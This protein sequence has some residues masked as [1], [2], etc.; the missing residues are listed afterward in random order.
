MSNEPSDNQRPDNVS[1]DAIEHPWVLSA[2]VFCPECSYSLQ[3]I[4]SDRCP[5]C[6]YEL[7]QLKSLESSIPW[8]RRKEI[9][10]WRAY[11]AT[12]WMV[13]FRNR[14]FCNEIAKPVSYR[15]SQ[16]YRWTTVVPAAIPFVCLFQILIWNNLYGAA[17]SDE[18]RTL[19]FPLAFLGLIVP[20]LVA[21]AATGWPSY[22][23]H[24]K[25]LPVAVQNRAIALSYYTS[26]PLVFIA[27]PVLFAGLA[28]DRPPT[29]F[30]PDT[31][32][33]WYII[34][35]TVLPVGIIL[36]WWLDILHVAHRSLRRQSSTTMKIAVLVPAGWFA[37]SFGIVVGFSMLVGI[38]ATVAFGV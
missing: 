17:D 21:A 34:L 19:V 35:A 25:H 12:M 5:E 8:T 24:P 36:P 2:D 3:G 14:E 26:G 37:L 7:A 23:F 13:M 38:V 15:D 27:I 9:G 6:G 32:T 16:S 28:I 30:G 4:A 1:G 20:L 18:L 11:V 10:F 29:K 22:F 33:A 31:V